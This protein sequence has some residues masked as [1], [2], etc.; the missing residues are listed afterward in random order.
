MDINTVEFCWSIVQRYI[1]SSD[2]INA[3]SHLVTELIDSGIRDEDL[4]RLAAI[5]E[6]FAEAVKEHKD[7][8]DSEY[9]YVDEDQWE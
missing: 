5:D 7:S 6:T 2:E 1:K 9:W 4:E 3:V 8:D